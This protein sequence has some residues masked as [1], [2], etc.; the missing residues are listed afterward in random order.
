MK[1]RLT[2]VQV[3]KLRPYFDRVC[4]TAVLGTPGILLA[5]LRLN[6]QTG[7]Y[8]MEPAFLPH[9]YAKLIEERGE[10][11]ALAYQSRVKR[12]A[13]QHSGEQNG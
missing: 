12:R 9:E 3:E 13:P 2:H 6:S 11:Y 1:V 4:A 5:R 7:E 8:T 10:R